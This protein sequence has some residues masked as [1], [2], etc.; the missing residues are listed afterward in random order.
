MFGK[1]NVRK[2]KCSDCK[3]DRFI[4]VQE[5]PYL[6]FQVPNLPYERGLR[7]QLVQTEDGCYKLFVVAI[8]YC[9]RSNDSTKALANFIVDR[10]QYLFDSP[11]ELITNSGYQPLNVHAHDL[12]ECRR[13]LETIIEDMQIVTEVGDLVKQAAQPPCL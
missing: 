3:Q 6:A 9:I 4:K 12:D 8:E 7:V 5:R 13:A 2:N 10:A 11:L 1:T